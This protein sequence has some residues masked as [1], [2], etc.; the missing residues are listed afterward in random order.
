VHALGQPVVQRARRGEDEA[1]DAPLDA[2]LAE[3]ARGDGVHLPV[4]LGVVLGRRVVGEAGEVD[5]AVDPVER[6]G[7]DV[8]HVGD[9]EVDA[10]RVGLERTV[11]PVQTIEDADV[12]AAVEQ[13]AGE[14]RADVAGAARDQD[15][16]ALLR[17]AR[18]EAVAASGQLHARGPDRRAV[19][20][21]VAVAVSA[22]LAVAVGGSHSWS[23]RPSW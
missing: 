19:G 18:A 15:R 6:R 11:A 1:L 10:I 13:P 17:R 21:A 16:L 5:D 23:N 2:G 14:D 7:W 3:R 20:L 9:D 8:A 4:G 12:V 22:H